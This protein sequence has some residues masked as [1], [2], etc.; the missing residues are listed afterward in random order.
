MK[1]VCLGGGESILR[2]SLMNNAI[3]LRFAKIDKVFGFDSEVAN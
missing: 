2:V 1:N 3:K